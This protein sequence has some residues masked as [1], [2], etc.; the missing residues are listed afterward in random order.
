MCW[1]D[2]PEASKKLI[3]S[4][5]QQIIVEIRRLEQEGDPIG[6]SVESTKRLLDH[7]WEPGICD[8]KH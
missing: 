7:L 1:Y 2:P 6:I 5:C 8:E 4:L 3:K